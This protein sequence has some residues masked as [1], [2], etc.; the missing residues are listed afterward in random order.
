MFL[1]CTCTRAH[2]LNHIHS[3]TQDTHTHCLSDRVVPCF[4]MFLLPEA[5]YELQ[6]GDQLMFA[7]ISCV[8]LREGA[9]NIAKVR[10]MQIY[11]TTAAMLTLWTLQ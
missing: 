8:Y 6:S 4:Q 11:M 3:Y 2:T 10:Q 7:D 1:D 9:V 5:K